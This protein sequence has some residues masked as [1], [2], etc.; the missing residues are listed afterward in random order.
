M[1][2]YRFRAIRNNTCPFTDMEV[3]I[4][5]DETLSID[6]RHTVTLSISPTEEEMLEYEKEDHSMYINESIYITVDVK[7]LVQALRWVEGWA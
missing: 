5:D 2:T 7:D 4:K 6:T 3:G 1:G